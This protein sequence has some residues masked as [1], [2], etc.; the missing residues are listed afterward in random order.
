MAT[1]PN[2]LVPVLV[3]LLGLAVALKLTSTRR[4][5]PEAQRIVNKYE[6]IMKSARAAL[7]EEV[8]PDDPERN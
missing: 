6:P 5:G 4:G 3:D 7:E 8:K 2:P 1:E